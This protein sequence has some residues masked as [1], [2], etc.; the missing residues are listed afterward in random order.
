MSIVH[1]FFNIVWSNEVIGIN[2]ENK[3]ANCLFDGGVSGCGGVAVRL[4]D[5]FD[6]VRER[7]RKGKARIRR[8]GADYLAYALLDAVVDG[9]FVVLEKVGESLELLEDEVMA[10]PT[11]ETIQGIHYLK[12]ELNG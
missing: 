2:A 5:V 3:S 8:M 4:G 11:P 6:P 1:H 9:Y 7:L 10:S 12:R